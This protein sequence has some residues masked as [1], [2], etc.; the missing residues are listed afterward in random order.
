M[1]H[2]FRAKCRCV[3]VGRQRV[4]ALSLISFLWILADLA[5]ATDEVLVSNIDETSS[6]FATTSSNALAQGFET[7]ANA[8]GYSLS[9]IEVEFYESS[10][11]N[12]TVTLHKDT[13]RSASVATLSKSGSGVSAGANTFTAPSGTKLDANSTYFVRI[14]TQGSVKLNITTSDSESSAKLGWSVLDE[15]HFRSYYLLNNFGITTFG[16]NTRALLIRVKGSELLGTNDAT[17]TGLGLSSGTLNPVFNADT[18][19]YNA[20]VTH[21][22][23]RITVEP[24]PKNPDATVEYLNVDDIAIGDADDEVDG[25]QVNLDTGTNT[26]KVKVTSTDAT[27][28]KTYTLTVSRASAINLNIN[29]VATDNVINIAEKRTGFSIGGDTGTDLGVSVTVSIGGIELSATSA[30]SNDSDDDS[31]ATWSVNVPA[32]ADYVSG[33]SLAVTVSAMK[34]GFTS[35]DNVVRTLNVDLTAPTAPTY[36]VPTSLRVGTAID[37]MNPTGGSGIDLYG[38]SGLPSGLAI[39]ASTG[40]ITGIPEQASITVADAVI[41]VS[42]TADNTATVS[43]AFPSVAKGEQTLHGFAYSVEAVTFGNTAPTVTVPTGAQTSLSY[44]SNATTVCTVDAATGILTILSAGT[45]RITVTAAAT[46]DWTGA[47]ASFTIVVT[48]S[49]TLVS[50][51]SQTASS[52]LFRNQAQAFTTG[53]NPGGYAL[54]SVSVILTRHTSPIVGPTIGVYSAND[55]GTPNA[56]VQALNEPRGWTNGTVIY[57]A[58]AGTTLEAET[59]YVVGVQNAHGGLGRTASTDEDD[60]GSRDWSIADKRYWRANTADSWQSASDVIR[61]A[62]DGRAMPGANDA[63]LTALDLELLAH[64]HAIT[65]NES[66]SRESVSYSA[67][68][69]HRDS[70]IT[71]NPTLSN[72]SATVQFLDA[73]DAPIADASATADGQQ[74]NL[75]VGANTIKVKVTAVNAITTKTYTVIVTRAAADTDATLNALNLSE[76]KLEPAFTYPTLT[77]AA[78]VRNAIERITVTAKPNHSDATLAYLD[79]DDNS[80]ADTDALTD[81]HQVDMKVGTNTIKVGVTA[82]DAITSRTYVVTVTR[83]I[84]PPTV[85]TN[86][87]VVAGDGRVHLGWSPP[88]ADGGSPV[89]RYEYRHKSV[90]HD[91]P[92]SWTAIPD[93][94]DDGV[95]ASDETFLTVLKLT[96]DEAHTFQLRAVNLIGEGVAAESAQVTPSIMAC[97]IPSYSGGAEEVFVATLTAGSG[98]FSSAISAVGFFVSESGSFG[99]LSATRFSVGSNSYEIDFI[100]DFPDVSDRFAI[101]FTNLPTSAETHQLIVYVCNT[102]FRLADRTIEDSSTRSYLFNDRELGLSATDTRLVSIAYDRVPPSFE[103]LMVNQAAVTLTFDETSRSFFSPA[104]NCFRRPSGRFFGRIS[105]H[106]CSYH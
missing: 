84:D 59:T 66:F 40:V 105:R 98:S 11:Q 36:I 73:T 58:P 89:L 68:V 49:S 75:S 82:P 93:G 2:R 91:Y 22:I 85:P 101:S 100:G 14:E 34:L 17:L 4:T 31:T 69:V 99:S 20:T 86:L 32:N 57:S 19:T 3:R 33:T 1:R 8:G 80:I 55:D 76:G 38:A 94:P 6:N 26:I 48:S 13:P 63:T 43:L 74:V 30:D 7:G 25:H 53:D 71:V 24:T 64:D 37:A 16:T 62:I 67:S 39:D 35:P 72:T 102:T 51:L 12:P 52:N 103:T 92:A 88:A 15:R 9:S 28:T 29:V 23:S 65:L 45:C 87:T 90:S 54:A 61:I 5:L 96:N 95:D 81:G 18:D 41:T 27:A 50:N 60:S 47:T 97:V 46:N 42:D 70:T 104:P 44:T 79:A 56:L 77:Y 83:T 21:T 106:R 78:S 10:T